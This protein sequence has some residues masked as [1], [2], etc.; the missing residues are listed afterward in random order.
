M[1][2]L[3]LAA[4]VAVQLLCPALLA[5]F[6]LSEPFDVGLTTLITLGSQIRAC[7]LTEMHNSLTFSLKTKKKGQSTEEM[8][9]LQP[10]FLQHVV[11]LQTWSH[12]KWL[13]FPHI[14][15][16]LIYTDKKNAQLWFI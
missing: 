3:L 12:V 9:P 6:S 1:F 2:A 10:S 11:T 14:V 7:V 16:F 5:L 8:F 15:F 4:T 13:A